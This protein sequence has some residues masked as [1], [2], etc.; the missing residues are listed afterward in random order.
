MFTFEHA[1]A[2]VPA[3]VRIQDDRGLLFLWIRH[4]N[5][6]AAYFYTLITTIAYF[7]V[8]VYGPVRRGRVGCTVYCMIHVNSPFKVCYGVGSFPHTLRHKETVN[9]NQEAM[10][11]LWPCRPPV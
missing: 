1:G 2:A 4:Q 10:R 6:R 7:R 5:I 11:V 9:G 8:K 3:L